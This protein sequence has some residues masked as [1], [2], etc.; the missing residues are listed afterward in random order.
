VVFLLA[1]DLDWG[2]LGSYGAQ[3]NETPNIDRLARDGM[4]FTDAYS[5]CTVCSPGRAAILSGH[6]PA[7]LL[8]TDWISGHERPN[9]KLS[10]PDWQMYLDHERVLLPE[11]VNEAGYAT[12]FFGKWHLIPEEAPDH[13]HHYPTHHDFDINVGGRVKRLQSLV[14]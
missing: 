6:Y 11:A 13:D 10:V 14:A 3:F 12:G 1:D 4:R 9:E 2:D 7:R 8:L 5:A